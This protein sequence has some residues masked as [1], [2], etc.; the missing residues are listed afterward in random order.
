[1]SRIK[2]ILLRGDSANPQK[3]SMFILTK[4]NKTKTKK[5]QKNE[6]VMTACADFL[7]PWH[8][9]FSQERFKDQS[10]GAPSK[11]RDV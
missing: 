11:T 1:M 10:S 7:E 5:K 3:L 9:S 2:Y 4:K 8:F 6:R